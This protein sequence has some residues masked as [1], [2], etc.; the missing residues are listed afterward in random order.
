MFKWLD[1]RK[2]SRRQDDLLAKAKEVSQ[3]K[4]DATANLL[5]KMDRFKID[6]ERRIVDIPVDIE[7][8]QQRIA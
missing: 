1:R 8:R 5:H 4:M 2:R 6:I 7:R 3:Q